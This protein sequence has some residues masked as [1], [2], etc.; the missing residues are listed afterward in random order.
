M[1]TLQEIDTH[2]DILE[3]L[4]ANEVLDLQEEADRQAMERD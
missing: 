1:A 4:D 2:Y 3:V